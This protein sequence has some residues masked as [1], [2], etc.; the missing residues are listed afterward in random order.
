MKKL[1]QQEEASLLKA[2]ARVSAITILGY[3]HQQYAP[4][5]FDITCDGA[6]VRA[7]RQAEYHE[8]RLVVTFPATPCSSLELAITGSYGPSPAIRELG[9]YSLDDVGKPPLPETK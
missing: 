5:D 4:R 7:V 2:A 9:I 6:T 8:N 3:Q 1:S